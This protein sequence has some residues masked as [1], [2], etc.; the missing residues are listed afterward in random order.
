MNIRG[1]FL[2]AG[3]LLAAS[4]ANAETVKLSAELKVLSDGI[5]RGVSQ[6][7]GLPQYVAGAQIGRGKLFAGVL[8][9]SMRDR[10]SGVDNQTQALIG[11]RTQIRSTSLTARAIFKQYNGTREG[12]DNEF[13]E[14]EVNLGHKLTERLTGKLN[15][16]YSDDTY[17]TR[18]K[19]ATYAEWGL[20][21]K[22]TPKLTLQAANGFRH[23]ENGTD[24]TSY[25]A[26][27]SYALAP[28]LSAAVTFTTTDKD[29]LGDKY[30]DALFVT[31]SK[32]F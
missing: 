3:V 7:E 5:Y 26:G 27:V 10:T 9:K 21:Y 20:D 8:Y 23:V 2:S 18:A 6:T 16:A 30:D 24:Y 22:L 11:Y 31:L 28:K 4:A 19:E 13:M 12:I 25:L 32:K 1:V 17:G 14:Y 29:H 15:L